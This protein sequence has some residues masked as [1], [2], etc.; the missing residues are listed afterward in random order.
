MGDNNVSNGYQYQPNWAASTAI[1]AGQG[2]GATAAPTSQGKSANPEK[3]ALAFLSTMSEVGTGQYSAAHGAKSVAGTQATTQGGP[4]ARLGAQTFAASMPPPS[5]PKVQFNASTQASFQSF[6][7]ESKAAMQSTAAYA[8]QQPG[9]Q[10]G[11]GVTLIKPGSNSNAQVASDTANW[12][13]NTSMGAQAFAN[14]GLYAF[15]KLRLEN[16]DK[17]INAMQDLASTSSDLQSTL[18]EQQ[19]AQADAAQKEA[20]KSQKKAGIMGVFQKAFAV[21][22]AVVC[23]VVACVTMDPALAALGIAAAAAA[24]TVAGAVKGKGKGGFDFFG[25]LEW[26]DNVAGMAGLT[27]IL[28]SAA[29][30][31]IAMALKGSEDAMENGAKQGADVAADAE[32]SATNLAAD[33]T[34]TGG[35]A[36]TLSEEGLEEAEEGRALRK[37]INKPVQAVQAGKNGD[38]AGAGKWGAFRAKFAANMAQATGCD[39][40]KEYGAQQAKVGAVMGVLQGA[41]EGGSGYLQYKVS[42]YQADADQSMAHFQQLKAMVKLLDSSYKTANDLVQTL[43]KSHS[44]SVDQVQSLLKGNND[45]QN[46]IATNMSQI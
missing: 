26:F 27:T 16:T 12:L 14:G 22:I 15:M 37:E 21:I 4:S 3:L 33:G 20:Q 29:K 39:G 1:D 19:A 43:V 8:A 23:V 40:M 35:D 13:S 10:Q 18:S 2:S 45:V 46:M 28:T 38:A 25:G 34:E 36:K 42:M 6:A 11:A 9:A 5:A 44:N 32:K 41:N 7:T 17:S 24:F 30:A 31:G